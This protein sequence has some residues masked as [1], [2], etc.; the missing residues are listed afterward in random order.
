MHNKLYL[1]MLRGHPKVTPAE[2]I[3]LV[4][5][6]GADDTPASIAVHLPILVSDLAH[7]STLQAAVVNNNYEAVR[8]LLNL[9]AN[10]D[11][12]DRRGKET[13][14]HQACKYGYTDIVELLLRRGADPYTHVFPLIPENKYDQIF[15]LI[16]SVRNSQYLPY[17]QKQAQLA[18]NM[19]LTAACGNLN[20]FKTILPKVSLDT[21][22]EPYPGKTDVARGVI[23]DDTALIAAC[24]G[25]HVDMVMQLLP[26]PSQ[27]TACSGSNTCVGINRVNIVGES[28][29]LAAASQGHPGMI[30]RLLAAGADPNRTDGQQYTPLMHAAT[31][32]HLEAVN[33]LIAAGSRVNYQTTSGC[34]AITLAVLPNTEIL[35]YE[36]QTNIVKALLQAGADPEPK[37][38]D[39]RHTLRQNLIE[40]E[41]MRALIVEAR[42]QKFMRPI[43]QKRRM[44]SASSTIM[45]LSSMTLY[46]ANKG[47]A[48]EHLNL[49]S[50][51][52]HARLHP[53]AATALVLA[54]VLTIVSIVTAAYVLPTACQSKPDSNIA[55]TSST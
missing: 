12:K 13:A 34:S 51:L 42:Q 27:P 49:G 25:G 1:A 26:G 55:C 52:H 44:L 18:Q 39:G 21:R 14:F 50:Y 32:G 54:A 11:Q 19:V 40:D 29:L 7:A 17:H 4:K 10:I 46:C 33:A 8:T 20:S 24:R 6:S 53:L 31:K 43:R 35:D 2:I 47:L 38:S 15:N 36:R 9:G 28:A 3:A 30:S 5:K 22:Y 41:D 48:V 37:T 45:L 23:R 16:I